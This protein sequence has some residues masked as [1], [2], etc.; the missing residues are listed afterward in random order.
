MKRE[1]YMAKNESLRNALTDLK[2]AT[3]VIL[4]N[5]AS[6]PVRKERLSPTSKAWRRP[7]ETS[8]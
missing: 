7:A 3:F 2:E 5:H 1:K 4:N 6:A 8:L